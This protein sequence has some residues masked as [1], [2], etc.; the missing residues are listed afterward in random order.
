[1][2]RNLNGGSGRVPPP[3]RPRAGGPRRFVRELLLRI[4]CDL[5]HEAWYDVRPVHGTRWYVWVLKDAAG[6]VITSCGVG[7]H[8][9]RESAAAEAES[10]FGGGSDSRRAVEGRRRRKARSRKDSPAAPEHPGQS[11]AILFSR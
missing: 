6:K 10:F 11:F 9:V 4:F 7:R 3:P 1:M 2:T 8:E 5:E